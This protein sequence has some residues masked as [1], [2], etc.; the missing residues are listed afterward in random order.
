MH[1]WLPTGHMRHHITGTNQCPG[2]ASTVKTIDHMLKCPHPTLK[3]KREEILKQLVVNGKH[4]KIPKGILTAFIQTLTTYTTGATEYTNNTYSR[5]I[6]DTI[7]QQQSIGVNMM[8]RGYLRKGWMNA[9]PNSR[10]PTRV[11]N[12]LQRMV[13][14]NFFEPLWQNRNK[15]L[16]QQKN[17]YTLAE[18]AVLDEQLKWYQ[19]NRQTLLAHHDHFIFHNID[20][21]TIHTMPS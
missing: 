1:G 9:V 19:S 16:Q 12:E 14:M 20:T 4:Q 21:A 8:A 11:M 10:H 3:K 2:C 18:D 5:K 7:T 13:W 15:L 17:N 6:Q